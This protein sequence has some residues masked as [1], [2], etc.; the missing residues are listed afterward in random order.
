MV[1]NQNLNPACVVRSNLFSGR[2]VQNY[3]DRK[4]VAQHAFFVIP[5]KYLQKFF[6]KTA[7][8]NMG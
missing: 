7:R 1:K 4:A 3:Q 6:L 5:I 2:E 8:E